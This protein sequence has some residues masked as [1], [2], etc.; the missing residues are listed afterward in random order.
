MMDG[1][2][3]DQSYSTMKNSKQG[4]GLLDALPDGRAE[5]VLILDAQGC[6]LDTFP[7]LIGVP[8]AK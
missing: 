1:I 5:A 3:A 4:S 2:R 7:P 6:F 8:G